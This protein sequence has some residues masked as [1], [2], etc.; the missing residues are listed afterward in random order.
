MYMPQ[1]KGTAFDPDILTKI[2]ELPVGCE[3]KLT[4][5]TDD[6]PRILSLEVTAAKGQVAV[7]HIPKPPDKPATEKP[8]VDKP[9]PDKPMLDKPALPSGEAALKADGW[10]NVTG[11]W[12]KKAEHIYDVTDGKLEAKKTNGLLQAVVHRGNG[13]IKI[14]VRNGF[15]D[16]E[17]TG[18]GVIIGGGSC[19]LVTPYM[20]DDIDRTRFSPYL[21]KTIKLAPSLPKD[22]IIIQ[23]QDSKL[24]IT[25]DGKREKLANY[26]ISQKGP[27]VIEVSGSATIEFPVC[28]DDAGL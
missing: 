26:K 24:Q 19:K 7:A 5:K 21:E 1:W 17:Y 27:F 13:T 25:V 22:D 15:D 8:P 20:G 18:F 11:N 4:Y 12:R 28:K 16:P 23:I 3:V 10:T 6:H 14:C 9:A 2:A